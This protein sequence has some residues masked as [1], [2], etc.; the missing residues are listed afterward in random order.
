M[1]VLVLGPSVSAPR[2]W[3]GEEQ[4]E[5]GH[6]RVLSLVLSDGDGLCAAKGLIE[7]RESV[8]ENVIN[9]C[10]ANDLIADVCPKSLLR[11]LKI[12]RLH[13]R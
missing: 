8:R 5:S 3:R 9:E 2:L 7:R 1:C 12:H 11:L 6:H 10:R 4:N 13:F